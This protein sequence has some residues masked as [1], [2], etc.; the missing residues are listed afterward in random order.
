MANKPGV[1]RI[2]E[3]AVS[4]RPFH[5]LGAQMDSYIYDQANRDCGV[6][7]R[8]YELIARRVKGIRPGVARVF[9]EL[10]W[11]CPSGDGQTFVWDGPEVQGLLRQL[12]LMQA[13]GT[14]ANLVLFTP[15]PAP[16]VDLDRLLDMM[17]EVLEYLIRDQG[18]TD[19]R[20]LTLW[21]EP[22]TFFVH[23]SALYR[24]IFGSKVSERRPW[25]DYV[26]INRRAHAAL[27][28]RGLYPA[29][30]LVVADTVYG[31]PL[32]MERIQCCLEAFGDIDV[33][34]GYHQYNPEDL[35][36][37]KGN[38]D[39]AYAGMAAEVDAFRRLLGE[40]RE[41]ML[42]E[43]NCA[44]K[45]GFG[46]YFAGVGPGGVDLVSS[47][48]GAIEVA[49]KVLAG[50]ASGLDGVSLWCLHDLIHMG[51]LRLGVM[52]YG[53]WRYKLQGW[54]P[55]P[56]YHYYGALMMAFPAGS[57]IHAV[58]GCAPGIRAAAAHTPDGMKVAILNTTDA[59]AAVE[60]PGC[61]NASLQTVDPAG[62]PVESDLPHIATASAGAI[63]NLLTLTVSPGALCIV[64][65]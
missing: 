25:G 2:V 10:S 61:G 23:D 16:A 32:R 15:V 29:L 28:A 46:T 45:A 22:D 49:D 8:D 43:F 30:K 17:L 60:V 35:G 42:W 52:P 36:Y 56:I 18:F 51:N 4:R 14:Q 41:L 50:L 34:Y 47:V 13:V 21:N 9:V 48:A 24:R 59:P 19:I 7:E 53:L 55:R 31:A 6:S 37:Y 40:D 11:F 64:K 27:V 44:G 38:L 54:L 3:E 12:R 65:L 33:S 26:R 20:W 63:D 1:L 57:A 58:E 5:G 39:F 62:L